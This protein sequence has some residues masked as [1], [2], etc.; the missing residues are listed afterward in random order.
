VLPPQFID[1]LRHQPCCG[2]ADA[3]S[4]SAVTVAGFR[5]QPIHARFAA[6]SARS[7]QDVFKM[8][9]PAPLT[10]RELSVGIHHF[11]F[12]S[13]IAIIS[14][15]IVSMNNFV[16]DIISIVYPICQYTSAKL[17]RCSIFQLM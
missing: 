6:F 1:V 3:L 5:R 4:A 17:A 2:R 9:I 15:M 11:Y 7:S 12:F 16:S 8:R 10:F 14:V 13:V